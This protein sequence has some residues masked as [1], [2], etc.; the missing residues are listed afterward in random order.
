MH[1][2]ICIKCKCRICLKAILRT[3]DRI[4]CMVLALQIPQL[5]SM[6][7]TL[8]VIEGETLKTGFN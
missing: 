8:W 4:L 1:L 7:V 2:T 6:V 3:E 5:A